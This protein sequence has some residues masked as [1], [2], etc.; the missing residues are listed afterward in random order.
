MVPVAGLTSAVLLAGCARGPTL[1]ESTQRLHSDA[2]A[3][4]AAGRERL[5]VPGA[6][7]RTLA[8]LARSCPDGRARREYRAQLPLRHGPSSAVVVD[9]A[10][11]VTL[12]LI[13]DRGYRLDRP[14]SGGTRRTFTMVR[15]SPAVTLTIRLRGGRQPT[16]VLDGSTPCLPD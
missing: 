1:S 13:G 6:R 8:D 4:L 15:E 12:G 16:L 7:P 5:G 3:V 10:A 9:Q 2:A 14:P 11:A